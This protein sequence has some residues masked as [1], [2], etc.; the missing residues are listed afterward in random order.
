MN[1]SKEQITSPSEVY[2]DYMCPICH[3][4]LWKPVDC[5]NCHQT[6]CKQCVSS[7]LAQKSNVCPSPCQNYEETEYSHK[8]YNLLHKFRIKCKNRDYGCCD[9][10]LYE[11]LDEH[12]QQHCQ[13]KIMVC[14]DCQQSMLK[15]DFGRHV[16]ICNEIECKTCHLIYK[17]KEQHQQID[18]VLARLNQYDR[19]IQLLEKANENLERKLQQVETI[20]N[21]YSA[22]GFVPGV[23]HDIS[24]TPLLSS[25][26]IIYDFPYNHV[27]TVEELRALKLKCGD[28]IIVGA[29]RGSSSTILKIA[30]IV[31]ADI[32]LLNSPVNQ[33]TKYGN[34]HWY[35]TPKYS[36]GFAPSS[37]TINCSPGDCKETDN[38]ENRLSWH[39]DSRGGYHAGDVKN[40]YSNTE[41]RKIIM[42]SKY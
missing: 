18:C 21:F 4:L 34:V 27:T 8:F 25:W 11:C 42:T 1:I 16:Q 6:F 35:L 36:F 9:Y 40:L 14:P 26:S 5:K 7:R 32:L 39:L 29:I 17:R 20:T 41:W 3:Y 30:A 22:A 13:Y 19:K 15:I 24:L 37:T 12:Q 10:L 23:A 28:Q 31:P 2:D 38:S 33:P